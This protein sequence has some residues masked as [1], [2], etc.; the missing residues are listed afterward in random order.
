MLRLSARG[1]DVV[2]DWSAG[3]PG[4]VYWGRSLGGVQLDSVIAASHRPVTQG[5]LDVVAP[6]ALIPEHGAGW[7]GRPGLLGHRRRGGDW[8]PR[9]NVIDVTADEVSATIRTADAVAGLA[10]EFDLSLDH[11]LQIS[12]TLTNTAD[13]RYLLDALLITLSVPAAATELLTLGGRWAREFQPSRQP[14]THGTWVAENRSGRSSQRH[15]PTVFAGVGGFG[16]W[17]GEVWGAHLG[18]SG[19]HQLV[20]DVLAD[21]RKVLQLGEL[22]H[23]G[24]VVLQP[25][26]VYRTPTVHAV[27]SADGLTPASWGFHRSLRARPSHPQR[28]RP[29]LI[30]TWEA[31]YF[32]HDLTTL[33]RLADVA[34]DVGAERYV[35]DDGW[36]GSRRDDRRGLGDWVVSA[37]AHPNGLGPLVD[38]VR[39]LGMEFGIWFEPEMVNPDS[40]LFRAHPEWALVTDGY[41]PVMG[42][43]QLVL[44][45]AIPEAYA[46][47]RD[48]LHAVLGDHDIAFVKWDM[49]RDHVQGSGADGA[50]GTHAQTIALYRLLDELRRLH[51]DVE[52]ES[53]SSGGGR[54]DF[55]IL[56][57]TD[58]VWTSDCNDALERQTIQRGVS[59][60]LPPELMG[61]HIGPPAAHTTGRRHRL[62]FR[63]VTALFGHLGIEWNILEL[64]GDQRA[65]LAALVAVHKRFR[66]L[67][68]SGDTVRFDTV[69][70]GERPSSHAYGVY[71]TDRREALVCV[72]QLVTG[73]GLTP[74]ALRM[75]ALLPTARYRVAVVDPPGLGARAARDG[76]PWADGI[77]L[78]GTQ[79][80]T[81]G[82]QLPVMDP[83]TA[84]LL[85][86]TLED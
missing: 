83:E 23:P 11:T 82:L 29:V 55:G 79:L 40:D 24:E 18:W 71:A 49:N 78:S 17:S 44:N 1:V 68:H 73:A 56:E 80:A 32:D 64:D 4:I 48:Q 51:P 14:F 21:G 31:V 20:A 70:N 30:N 10:L 58:R 50:A 22:L 84:L 41:Q 27:C 69:P 36:F 33:K 19:N 66:T 54:V 37:D 12:A 7:P 65:R 15:V 57:R 35:L 60:F 26:E 9:F 8:A 59:T 77:V 47:V 45:L 6:S 76:L 42:R 75:P 53:C 13:S 52:F 34:A 67:L 2:V 72:A 85:H 62:A 3:A 43:H 28:P 61:A 81:H 16:E 63:G 46:H 25:G 86:L 39:S 38:H 5:G 74:P